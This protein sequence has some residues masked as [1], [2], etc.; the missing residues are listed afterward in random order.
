MRNVSTS[1][2]KFKFKQPKTSYFFMNFPDLITLCPG[3]E[4][5]IDVS[6]RPIRSEVYDDVI[7]FNSSNGTFY[8]RVVATLPEFGIRMQEFLDFGFSTVKEENT[9]SFLLRNV[10]DVDAPF[11]LLAEPPFSLKADKGARGVRPTAKGIAGVISSGQDAS[12]SLSFVPQDASVFVGTVVCKQPDDR[13][14]LVMKISGIGKLPFLQISVQTLNFG[15]VLT[16]KI[17]AMELIL[18]NTTLVPVSFQIQP[19]AADR[20]PV[21]SWSAHSG[22]VPADGSLALTARYAPAATGAFDCEYFEITTP[23]GNHHRV[24]CKGRAEPHNV[25]ISPGAISFGN[26]ELGRVALRTV[27]VANRTDDAAFYQFVT[28]PAG[29]FELARTDGIV[30]ARSSA[31][32]DIRFRARIPGNFYRRLFLLVKNQGPLHVDLVAT[33]Y[34]PNQDQVSSIA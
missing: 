27:E 21:F 34:H 22:R 18:T 25:V 3:M 33:A 30:A 1:T 19:A 5:G 8:I 6:F 24:C 10:G 11:E 7:E 26:L 16:G 31:H 9:K 32:L 23:G 13:P 2:I 15:G 14:T 20:D 29:C 28:E 4:V 17:K 12:I